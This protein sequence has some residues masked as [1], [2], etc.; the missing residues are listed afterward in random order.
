M[1]DTID[2]LSQKREQRRALRWARR[3][4]GEAG[5]GVFR[6][7]LGHHGPGAWGPPGTEPAQAVVG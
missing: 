4:I 1:L 7:H 2:N 5:P 6:L 3:R